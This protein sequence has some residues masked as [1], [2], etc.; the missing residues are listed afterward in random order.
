MLSQEII[1]L[2]ISFKNV[3]QML[4]ISR[5][6]LRVLMRRDPEF[7]VAIKY[8]KSRQAPVFFS[9]REL[10]EWHNKRKGQV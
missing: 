10:V 5:D 8:G 4:D 3:C 2:Q 1:P 9:Y 7:P 6:T